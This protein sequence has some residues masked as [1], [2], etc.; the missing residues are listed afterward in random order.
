MIQVM[1]DIFTKRY[2][3]F[4]RLVHETDP[5]C[6]EFPDVF[7]PDDWEQASKATATAKD[8]CKSCPIMLDCGLYAIEA[9]EPHGVWGG[10]TAH[11]RRKIRKKLK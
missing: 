2:L 7:F 11:E 9:K 1:S 5:P 3:R 4:L 6:Q 10:M 8:Y